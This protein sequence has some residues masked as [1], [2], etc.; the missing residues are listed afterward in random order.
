MP[1]HDEQ[2][3]ALSTV[4][5]QAL[6][7]IH[8]H[9]PVD[10]SPPQGEITIHYGSPLVTVAN[11]V[12]VQRTAGK[13]SRFNET[14]V[15]DSSFS[16]MKFTF[17]N[18]QRNEPT[19]MALQ[20]NG[21]IVVGGLFGLARLNSGGGLDTA[22]WRRLTCSFGITGALIQKNGKIVAVGNQVNNQTGIA[23]LMLA[24]I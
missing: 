6:D 19:T 17:G 11:T 8:W 18:Q 20:S 13:I 14:G 16:S 22:F 4:Q 15:V 10:L 12:I 3:S 9:V 1:S 21:Q 7:T 2:H 5:S 24:R 23:T